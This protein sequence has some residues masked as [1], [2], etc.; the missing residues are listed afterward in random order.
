MYP[1]RF[2]EFFGPSMWRTLHAVAFTYPNNPS[3]QERKNYIDFFRSVGN[4]I[5]CPSCGVHYRKY[6]D[7]HPL[8]ADSKDSLSRWV[9]DLHQDVNKRSGKSGLTWEQV[10]DDYTNWGPENKNKLLSKSRKEQIK[11]LGDPYFGRDIEIGKNS[12]AMEGVSTETRSTV[13]IVLLV[14]LAVVLVLYMIRKRRGM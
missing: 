4:V 8:E 2:V 7:E 1:S 11:A 14:V 13:G 12:E 5:P 3:E 9:Y 10:K 6:M